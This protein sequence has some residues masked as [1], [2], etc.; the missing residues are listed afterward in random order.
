MS[1]GGRRR[2]GDKEGMG[3]RR[4]W[5]GVGDAEGIVK[6]WGQGG[7]GDN[8]GTARGWGWCRG[9]IQ[10]LGAGSS[11]MTVPGLGLVLGRCWGWQEAGAGAGDSEGTAPGLGPVRGWCWGWGW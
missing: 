10:C 9:W 1:A 8:E 5:Q 3:T 11:E 7:V 6:G 4:G 2:D